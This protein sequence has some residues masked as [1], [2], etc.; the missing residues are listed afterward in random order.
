MNRAVSWLVQG[1]KRST[2]N[3]MQDFALYSRTWNTRHVYIPVL[4][5]NHNLSRVPAKG[6]LP[7]LPENMKS[8]HIYLC[9]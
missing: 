1:Y 6:A 7:Y 3:R 2:G 5:G 4:P 9:I 8:P